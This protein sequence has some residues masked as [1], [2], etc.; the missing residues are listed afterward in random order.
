MIGIVNEE[1]YKLYDVYNRYKYRGSHLNVTFYGTWNKQNN[2]NVEL[3]QPKLARRSNFH[4]LTL[5][6]GFYRVLCFKFI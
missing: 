6:A 3:S 2:L 4:N 5:K 1:D